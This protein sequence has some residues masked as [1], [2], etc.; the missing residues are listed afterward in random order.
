LSEQVFGDIYPRYFKTNILINYLDEKGTQIIN[1]VFLIDNVSNMLNKS[2]FDENGVE[3]WLIDTNKSRTINNGYRKENLKSFHRRN[4]DTYEFSDSSYYMYTVDYHDIP[5][6]IKSL[7]AYILNTLKKADQLSIEEYIK[8]IA[9]IRYRFLR[10]H[11]FKDG[12]GRTSRILSNMLSLKK[13]FAIIFDDKEEDY[14][15]MENAYVAIHNNYE[16]KG[17]RDIYLYDLVNNPQNC[18]TMESEQAIDYLTE[19]FK[20]CVFISGKANEKQEEKEI[21]T[22]TSK[23]VELE[24]LKNSL[25]ANNTNF[26]R[27][28]LET[29][30]K[31]S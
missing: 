31:K 9:T 13:G 18:Q 25:L 12:N 2:F 20:K 5:K 1:N 21:Q 10:I 14:K 11:P 24:Q 30:S 23:K 7:S 16:V 28:A 6:A 22:S 8:E 29:R 27:E 15:A 19:Y 26:Q 17:S 4:Y 3:K